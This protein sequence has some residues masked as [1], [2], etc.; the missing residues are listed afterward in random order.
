MMALDYY[1]K[2]MGG[3]LIMSGGEDSFG[4]GGYE[5]TMI[6]NMMPVR[7]DSE[8][9]KE[10]PGHRARALR[11][12]PLGLDA[13]RQ[14]RGREG[15]GARDDRRAVAERFH[16]RSSLFDSEAM[17]LVR[18]QRAGNRRDLAR[19]PARLQSGGGT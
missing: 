19:D 5:R 17:V 6:E 15:I 11:D 3:G 4:S 9:M 2:T 14:A 10:Q 13:R 8:K 18:P 1:V 12:G 7:F 16:P